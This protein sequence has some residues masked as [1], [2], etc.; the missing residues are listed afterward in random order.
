MSDFVGIISD[1]H[2]LLRPEALQALQGC[3]L[4]IHAGDVGDAAILDELRAIAPVHA[5]RG[6]VD[7][8]ALGHSLPEDAVVEW[9][10]LQIYVLHM[11]DDLDLDPGAAGFAAVIY[12]HT[13]K[14]TIHHEDEVLYLN[15]G[16]AGH[17]RF[18]LPVT[19]AH[20]TVRDG[21]LHAEHV[22]LE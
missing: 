4:I 22:S 10:S 19:V 18:S 13:H 9:C 2:G 17:R 8:G 14:P 3:E 12:G 5:V 21:A 7:H 1:T 20:L 16:S 11:L 15:P 6:N